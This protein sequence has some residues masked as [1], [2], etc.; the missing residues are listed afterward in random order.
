MRPTLELALHKAVA[1]MSGAR[2]HHD[3]WWIRH[4]D[5]WSTLRTPNCSAPS[6]P[7]STWSGSG[8]AS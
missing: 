2:E 6:M 5:P 7:C 8:C 1:L 3:P 4:R